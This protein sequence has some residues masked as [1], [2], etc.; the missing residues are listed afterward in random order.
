MTITHER[1]RELN[2]QARFAIPELTK[3]EIEKEIAE[4][5]NKF[6]IEELKSKGHTFVEIVPWLETIEETVEND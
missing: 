6:I 2:K 1:I 4:R 3:E 5:R